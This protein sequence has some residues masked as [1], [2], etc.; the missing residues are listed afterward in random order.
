MYIILNILAPTGPP[1]NI[2]AD[3]INSTSIEIDWEEPT[4][5]TQ[6]GIIVSYYI[7]LTDLQSQQT[8]EYSRSGSHFDIVISSLH[9]YYSYQYAIAAE[10]VVGRGPLTSPAMIRTKEDGIYTIFSRIFFHI[11]VLVWPPH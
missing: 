9:P 11:Q 2:S 10:T 8:K 5:S 6:N 3:S 4:P 1:K 7:I